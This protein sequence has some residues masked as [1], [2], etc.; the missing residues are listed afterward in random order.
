MVY[1]GAGAITYAPLGFPDRDLDTATNGVE[2]GA[3]DAAEE[4]LLTGRTDAHQ[5]TG[6]GCAGNVVGHLPSRFARLPAAHAVDHARRGG[7]SSG[8]PTRGME[9]TQL[10]SEDKGRPLPIGGL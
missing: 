5:V 2:L 8:D 10:T 4:H 9:P 7:A 6:R 1:G 3:I